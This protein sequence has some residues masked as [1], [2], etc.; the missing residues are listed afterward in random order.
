VRRIGTAIVILSATFV[1]GVGCVPS[2]DSGEPPER[3]YWL[4]TIAL[5]E[6]AVVGISVRVS[7]VPGLNS[8]RIRILEQDQR[9]NY[10][11]GA[12]WSDSL[13]PLLES[14][15]NRSLNTTGVAS[16]EVGFRVTIERFF[17]VQSG[18]DKVSHITLR[19][20]IEP[21]KLAMLCLF[22]ERTV[23]ATER[24]RDVV[25]AHQRLLDALTVEVN[26]L[27]GRVASQRMEGC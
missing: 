9:L 7:V 1:T 19:A 18:D 14:V 15:M 8:D 22:E 2:L 20:R 21:V 10:Y 25:A 12:F 13:E 3:V 23:P 16:E 27:A 26:R 11:A 6:A 24:L 17:A 4:E 5:D